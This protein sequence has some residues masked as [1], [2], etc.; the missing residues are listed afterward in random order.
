MD[1]NSAIRC[2]V[3]GKHGHTVCGQPKE[4]IQTSDAVFCPNCGQEG[5]HIDYAM[6]CEDEYCT[7]PKYEAH[8]RYSMLTDMLKD[9]DVCAVDRS[10]SMRHL[11]NIYNGLIGS[12]WSKS[13]YERVQALFPSL[14]HER[15]REQANRHMPQIQPANRRKTFGGQSS[16]VRSND[17]LAGMDEV[18]PS[19]GFGRKRGR[20]SE[21][22]PRPDKGMRR[23]A[24]PQAGER[25]RE[26][27]RGVNEGDSR[28]GYDRGHASGDYSQ[29]ANSVQRGGGRV[30]YP[31]GT[32]TSDVIN[33]YKSSGSRTK[34]RKGNIISEVNMGEY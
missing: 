3:C 19:S 8:T 6:T 16:S 12:I 14:L 31:G 28:C 22:S 1:T 25:R 24:T 13:E 15:D 29:R 2:I 32:S 9:I 5:H 4:K 21:D 30:M 23:S 17:F 26:S 11:N 10:R 34:S 27:D 20:E 18:L 7:V 33:M